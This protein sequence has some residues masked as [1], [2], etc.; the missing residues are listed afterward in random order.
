MLA[1]LADACNN[2]A[3]DPYSLIGSLAEAALEIGPSEFRS[4]PAVKVILGKV[5]CLIGESL[6]P[7]TEA[8]YEYE[9]WRKL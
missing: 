3:C 8:Q 7:T 6:G 1:T 2:G 9:A 5:T 4:H